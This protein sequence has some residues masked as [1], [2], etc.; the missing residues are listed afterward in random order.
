MLYYEFESIHEMFT[1]K[2]LNNKTKGCLQN[3]F[4]QRMSDIAQT[5]HIYKYHY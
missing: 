4:E 1:Q 2:A 5:T 3:L